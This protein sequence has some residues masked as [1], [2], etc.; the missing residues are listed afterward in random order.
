MWVQQGILR[1][2]KED[3]F[4]SILD[5]STDIATIE[6]LSICFRWVESSGSRVEHF[7]GLVSLS[8]CDAASI[9]SVLKAFLADSDIG[10]GKL[11]GQRYDGTATF[12]GTKNGVQ[13]RIRTLAPR[14][15]FVHCRAHV[16]QLCCISAA[17]CLPSLK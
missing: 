9:Y 8:A 10:A 4:Y 7:L 12:S 11:R 5:E 6:E 17:R 14:A 13:M 3:A 16:L 2:L 15:L 1:S